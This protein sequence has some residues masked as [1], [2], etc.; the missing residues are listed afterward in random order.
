MLVVVTIEIII[1]LPTVLA[2]EK[3]PKGS[4]LSDGGADAIL[5]GCLHLHIVWAAHRL[6]KHLKG[7]KGM[8]PTHGHHALT[9]IACSSWS[10][11]QRLA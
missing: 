3:T 5:R 7:H 11:C 8:D 10:Q 2:L 4:H 1:V 9:F 6:P